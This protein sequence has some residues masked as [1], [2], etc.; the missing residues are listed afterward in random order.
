MSTITAP[1]SGSIPPTPTDRADAH[2]LWGALLPT[3]S[4]PA[5]ARVR[6]VSPLITALRNPAAVALV[7]NALQER[8]LRYRQGVAS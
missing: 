4:D 8:A 5:A 6:D 2:T 3:W 1:T 7:A